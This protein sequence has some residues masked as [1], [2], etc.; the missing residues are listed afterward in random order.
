[1]SLNIKEPLSES[2]ETGRSSSSIR[3]Y[4]SIKP[5]SNSTNV[6]DK[7]PLTSSND[8]TTKNTTQQDTTKAKDTKTKPSLQQTKFQ[9]FNLKYQKRVNAVTA[10]ST[11]TNE[12]RPPSLKRSLSA[13]SPLD[14]A[15]ETWMNSPLCS[16]QMKYDNK[17]VSWPFLINLM[18]CTNAT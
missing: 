17:I 2:T 11:P 12:I 10:P 1:M 9:D 4:F 7:K 6:P 13:I 14:T 3:D 16:K 15:N 18:S 5:S 8:N